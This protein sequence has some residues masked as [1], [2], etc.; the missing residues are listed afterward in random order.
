LDR[1]NEPFGGR[2]VTT[3]EN[4]APFGQP[5]PDRERLNEL[6]R[7]INDKSLPWTERDAAKNELLLAWANFIWSRV[8]RRTGG[9]V[10]IDDR[11]S[12]LFDS[13]FAYLKE[14]AS[15]IA[16]AVEGHGFSLLTAVAKRLEGWAVDKIRR[17]DGQTLI[18][19]KGREKEPVTTLDVAE[20]HSATPDEE[21]VREETLAQIKAAVFS[22]VAE[23]D[24]VEQAVI[25][26]YFGLDG[27]EMSMREVADSQVISLSEANNARRRAQNKLRRWLK[28]HD[29][30]KS[31]D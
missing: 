22:A 11:Q 20:G 9:R 1:Y 27:P 16:E 5:T 25:L 13:A 23:L 31:D 10:G 30:N 7:K 24:G 18:R 8:F 21:V 26:S 4:N 15:K 3:T 28:E 14:R 12:E 2:A 6:I 19:G 29:P 17:S